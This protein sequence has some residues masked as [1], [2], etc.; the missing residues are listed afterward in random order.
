MIAVWGL[1]GLI[2]FV[3]AL[4]RATGRTTSS[5]VPGAAHSWP[6]NLN[7]LFSSGATLGRPPQAGPRPPTC[8]THTQSAAPLD[9]HLSGLGPNAKP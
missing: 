9:W 8:N 3:V 1:I 2:F 5:L 4:Y 7:S 6:V